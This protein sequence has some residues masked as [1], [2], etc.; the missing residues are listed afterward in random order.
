MK[1]VL[2]LNGEPPSLSRLKEVG[3][4]YP[5]FAADGGAAVCMAAGVKPQWVAGDFDSQRLKSLPEDWQVHHFPEQDRTDF[6]KVLGHL[7]KEFDEYLIL[8]GLGQRTDHFLS[9]LVIVMALAD[10]IRV[11]FEGEGQEIHRVTPAT[12]FEKELETGGRLSLIPLNRSGGVKTSG[13]KWNL[14]DADMG[15]GLQLGQSNQI[16]ESSVKIEVSQGA[17]FV[18]V[19][20]AV[21]GQISLF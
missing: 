1:A 9:N 8:G 13:L 7:P 18:W 4:E 3:R 21:H 5:V 2:V 12:P 10:P 19:E 20:L 11:I 16:E 6:Q 17:L 14:N 15:P